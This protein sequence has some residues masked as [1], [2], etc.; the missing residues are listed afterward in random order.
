MYSQFKYNVLF[1][2]ML[3][4]VVG[5]SSESPTQ[6]QNRNAW[7]VGPVQIV[8]ETG[9]VKEMNPIRKSLTPYRFSDQ[10]QFVRYQGDADTDV[11][12]S[13]QTLCVTDNDELIA[14][15]FTSPI[16]PKYH[17]FEFLNPQSV[18]NTNLSANLKL[19]CSFHFVAR[20]A[21]GDA[22]FF[23]L[24]QATIEAGLIE[25]DELPIYL[26]NLSV[27][28]NDSGY[29]EIHTDRLAQYSLPPIENNTQY[30]LYCGNGLE[31][32]SP[33]DKENKNSFAFKQFFKMST[34]FLDSSLTPHF[35][36]IF[37]VSSAG[38]ILKQSPMLMTKPRVTLPSV[39]DT[40]SPVRAIGPDAKYINIAQLVLFNGS[41][42][43]MT[44]GF[45]EGLAN[46][47]KMRVA[48][49][50]DDHHVWG[51]ELL[52]PLEV[53]VRN[54]KIA[55]NFE[56]TRFELAPLQSAI[57][58][59]RVSVKNIRCKKTNSPLGVYYQFENPSAIELTLLNDIAAGGI[60]NE[61]ARNQIWLNKEQYVHTRLENANQ[62]PILIGKYKEKGCR[63]T[64]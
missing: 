38:Q 51:T 22:H 41:D 49:A 59:F 12:L 27:R 5:C 15:E 4:T 64:K 3:A 48:A 46:A 25:D 54:I 55:R 23:R 39:S 60:D 36:Q 56:Q 24:P 2:A 1:F 42:K 28:Q 18:Y 30:R 53:R 43:P 21:R 57:V 40:T 14:H 34:N 20:N 61:L 9:E 45:D 35:C 32:T 50:Q 47:V 11:Q 62:P 44:I 29:V 37:L 58:D 26:N 52:A 8:S 7:G 10:L 63:I 17:F 13:V 33:A 19:N 16:K 6:T 31:A